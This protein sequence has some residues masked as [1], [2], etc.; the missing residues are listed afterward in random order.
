MATRDVAR[1]ALDIRGKINFCP[2]D[3]V[4]PCG[5][6]VYQHVAPGL[7]NVSWDPA[8][9]LQLRVHVPINTSHTVA[10]Q[11]RR[12]LFAAAVASWGMLGPVERLQW[13]KF[14][15]NHRIPGYNEYLSRFLKGTI[16][17]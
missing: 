15:A 4:R 10:Q 8:R 13:R 3:P 11:E 16:G 7:G 1:L 14:G 17:V 2:A 12:L 9:R 5:E 6:Y